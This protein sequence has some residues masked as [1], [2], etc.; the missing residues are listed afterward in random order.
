MIHDRAPSIER[1]GRHVVN[2]QSNHEVEDKINRSHWGNKLQTKQ[3]NK[4]IRT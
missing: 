1:N 4:N 2:N 3:N